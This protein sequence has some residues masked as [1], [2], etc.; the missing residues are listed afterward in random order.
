[1]RNSILELLRAS[2]LEPVS[3]EKISEQLGVSRT[4]MKY[5]SGVR[6]CVFIGTGCGGTLCDH[7]RCCGTLDG[8]DRDCT[9][10]R[11]DR[12]PDR[13]NRPFC[14]FFVSADTRRTSGA[15]VYFSQYHRQCAGTGMGL[16]T[17]GAEGHGGIG[18]V[19]GGTGNAGIQNGTGDR[20]TLRYPCRQQ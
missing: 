10:V 16:H 8:D 2:G 13:K 5:R 15:G 18:T 9:A 17:G 19:G 12:P 11:P 7:D 14:A 20:G 4:A 6:G 3:G 1:M